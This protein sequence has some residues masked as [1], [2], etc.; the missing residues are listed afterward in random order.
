MAIQAP[1]GTMDVL[2][3]ESWKWQYLE[4][5]VRSIADKFGYMEVRTP[6]FEHT[7]LFVRGVGDTTDIV[8]KEMYTF[9]D[10]GNRSITL[11]PENTASAV[12]AY[13]EHKLY[14]GPQPSKMY[15]IAPVFRYEK[16]QAGRLREHHQFGIECFGSASPLVDADTINLAMTV[17]RTLGLKN[18]SLNINSIGCPECRPKYRQALVEYFSAYKGDL[19]ET[20][21]SRLDRNP[22]RILDC[23]NPDC[24]KIVQNAPVTVDHLC[25]DC[26]DHFKRLQEC[27]TAVGLDFTIDTGIVRGLDYYT[28]TVFEIIST[29]LGAQSTVCGGGR[30]DGLCEQIDGPKTPG[31]GFGMGLERTLMILEKQDL[32]EAHRPDQKRVYVAAIDK[33]CQLE[34]VK[35]TDALR[36]AGIAA[37][38]DLMDRS[39]KAQMKYAGKEGFTHTV[40][41]GEDEMNSKV[42]QLKD[43]Q[44]GTQTALTLS[45]MIEVLK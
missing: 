10:K 21:L 3:A 27:L 7:E 28:K 8:E 43:M 17:F 9:Q 34:G 26:S 16:P 1:R 40:I 4:N 2:P 42:Y 12:R 38:Q 33:A 45:E 15:Y 22:L 5:T 32:L 24:K 29:D 30:Y 6:V 36:K 18:L 44:Q 39:F 25:D 19:C 37:D 31:I 41:I 14:A 13:V 35:V 11:K 23:K 20:C